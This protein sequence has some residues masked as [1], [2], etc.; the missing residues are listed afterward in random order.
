MPF[1]ESEFP[2]RCNKRGRSVIPSVEFG[3]KLDFL[4]KDS[5]DWM[6]YGR[7]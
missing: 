7:P 2:A 1:E 3:G 6:D 5:V 4:T